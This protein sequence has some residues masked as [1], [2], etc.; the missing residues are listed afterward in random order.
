MIRYMGGLGQ[1]S[2]PGQ[3]AYNP[4]GLPLVPGLIEVQNGQVAI[5]AWAGG[6]LDPKT[7]TGG[8]R[9]IP[10]VDWVPY[11]APT[12][13]TPSFA[14]YFSGH[15]TF[16]RAAAEVLTGFTGSEYFP[17]G[18]SIWTVKAGSL[19]F[20]AGPANDVALQWATYFDA[21]DQAGI[22]RL[23]GGIHISADDLAGRRA[24]AECGR[25]AWA[26][27]RRYFDGSARQ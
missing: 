6:P 2:E 3:P 24:G 14:G 9:W 5:R 23:Y 4:E 7:Q 1:S 27:A 25:A 15:S 13:V 21:A 26:Q 19:K 8:V 22:S 20:E 18:L 10:A 11:Q 12:F 16:S 17:G